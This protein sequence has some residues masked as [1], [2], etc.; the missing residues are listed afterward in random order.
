[1]K[2][3]QALFNDLIAA[4][5]EAGDDKKQ[6]RPRNALMPQRNDLMLYRYYWHMEVNRMR[7]DDVLTQLEREFFI[8]GVRIVAVLLEP[9]HQ[10]QLREIIQNK[11]AQKELEKIYPHINWKYNPR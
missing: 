11:P 5:S 9:H 3:Q 2:G 7:F 4:Q 10:K 6:Q 8:V 1:M